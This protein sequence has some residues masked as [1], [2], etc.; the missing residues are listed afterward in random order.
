MTSAVAE[1]KSLTE[2]QLRKKVEELEKK[3][4]EYKQK[5]DAEIEKKK[6]KL[7]VGYSEE[8]WNRMQSFDEQVYIREHN[9]IRFSITS[10][11]WQDTSCFNTYDKYPVGQ[12]VGCLIFYSYKY[13]DDDKYHRHLE[14]RVKYQRNFDV[15]NDGKTTEYSFT[16][17]K[18]ETLG[19][20]CYYSEYMFRIYPYA[21]YQAYHALIT[22]HDVIIH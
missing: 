2:E 17:D 16:L 10:P 7:R 20:I 18:D 1:S 6:L 9:P 13:R 4:A 8:Y 22:F 12:K 19:E 5:E 11:K 3:L 21:N 15:V 14:D